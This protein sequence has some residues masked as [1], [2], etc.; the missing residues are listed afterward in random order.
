MDPDQYTFLIIAIV[1]VIM[2]LIITTS[3]D[4][5]RER[6]TD[7]ISNHSTRGWVRLYEGWGQ[8]SNPPESRKWEL[9]ETVDD[10]RFKKMV[11]INLKSYDIA[12]PKD[13]HMTIWAIYPESPLPGQS[14][15]IYSA[16]TDLYNANPAKYRKV[17]EISAGQRVRG[18]VDFPVKHIM[19]EGSF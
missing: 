8:T 12:V 13:G 3:Q 17:V 10:G 9:E 15:G 6:L 5:L 18:S 19:V 4:V 11:H 16:Y 1:V 2:I 14:A 7:E